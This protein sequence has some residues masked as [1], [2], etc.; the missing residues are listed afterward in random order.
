MRVGLVLSNKGGAFP[1]MTRSLPFGISNYFGDGSQ[2]YSY[3]HIDDLVAMII[4]SIEHPIEGIYNAV[5]ER[6]VTNREMMRM[7]GKIHQQTH[8]AFPVPKFLLKLV[9]GE[10]VA[11]ILNSTRVSNAKIKSEGFSFQ[12]NTLEEALTDL[13]SQK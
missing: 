11:T 13:I 1:E 5:G 4:F 9:L 3:I 12:F 8:V 7:V 6:P 10:R 2:Y